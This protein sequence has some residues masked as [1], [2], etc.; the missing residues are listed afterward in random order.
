LFAAAIR[1][2]TGFHRFLLSGSPA[3]DAGNNAYA[4]D[5]DQR[6]PGYP[7]IVNGMIDIGAFEVQAHAHGRPIGQPLPDALLVSG[8]AVPMD[9]WPLWFDA[10]FPDPAATGGVTSGVLPLPEAP[11]DHRSVSAGPWFALS[12]EGQGKRAGQAH[13]QDLFHSVSAPTDVFAEEM[14]LAP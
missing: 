4:T 3:I 1:F 11:A 2:D 12:H 5:W 14:G 7:R 6:G 9:A 13:V 8:L 10:P